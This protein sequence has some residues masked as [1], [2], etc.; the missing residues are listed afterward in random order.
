[1]LFFA[2]LI[3]GL[4]S[5]EGA[6]VPL[7]PPFLRRRFIVKFPLLTPLVK[8]S[9]CVCPPL[10]RRLHEN[11]QA[12]H[13]G[14]GDHPGPLVGSARRPQ[15]KA[16]L[17]LHRVCSS[18]RAPFP[19]ALPFVFHIGDPDNPTRITNQMVPPD[20]LHSLGRQQ[21]S[22]FFRGAVKCSGPKTR[23]SWLKSWSW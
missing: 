17:R 5:H 4:V 23:V 2:F 11:P 3:H 15:L 6:W 14:S 22:S 9:T 18:S 10:W 21:S 1:M 8:S 16:I 19:F 13:H 7:T 20:S 12:K